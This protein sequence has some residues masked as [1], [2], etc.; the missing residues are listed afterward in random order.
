MAI[1]PTGQPNAAAAAVRVE[2]SSSCTCLA[3]PARASAAATA[4]VFGCTSSSSTFDIRDYI[5]ECASLPT[6]ARVL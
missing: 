5:T 1:A 2:A 6:M 4:C 3:A